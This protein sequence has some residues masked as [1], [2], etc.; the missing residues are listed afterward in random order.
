LK[1]SL[2][3]WR[4]GQWAAPGFYYA[5]GSTSRRKGLGVF[6]GGREQLQMA[7][8]GGTWRGMWRGKACLQRQRSL[9]RVEGQEQLFVK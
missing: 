6:A 4:L 5:A 3:Q 2:V 7:G 8:G 1:Q 9:R